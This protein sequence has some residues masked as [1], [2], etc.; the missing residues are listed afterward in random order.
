MIA[1]VDSPPAIVHTARYRER[2]TSSSGLPVIVGGIGGGLREGGVPVIGE[3]L[4][5]RIAP[6]PSSTA[7]CS[8]CPRG[9][10]VPLRARYWSRAP[11]I[12]G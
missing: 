9:A 12:L 11:R 5:T 1:S 6:R 10:P 3:D 2:R 7:P 8:D 4:A